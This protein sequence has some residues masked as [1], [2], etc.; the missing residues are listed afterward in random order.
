MEQVRHQDNQICNPTN[1]I[2]SLKQCIEFSDIKTEKM[3]RMSP[4]MLNHV[5]RTTLN[6]AIKRLKRLKHLIKTG[7]GW[8]IDKIKGMLV[9]QSWG[10][11]WQ[12]VR[13]LRE[14]IDSMLWTL[15]ENQGIFQN[16]NLSRH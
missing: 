13:E 7:E 2:D 12:S 3:Q 10:N 8:L 14:A 5:G 4:V 9:V 1:L 11:E 15:R 16:S 6:K